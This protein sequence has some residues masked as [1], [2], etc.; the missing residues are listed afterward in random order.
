MKSIVS[1]CGFVHLNNLNNEFYTRV[2]TTPSILDQAITDITKSRFI[3][4]LFDFPSFDHRILLIDKSDKIH[5][6]TTNVKTTFTTIDY[7]QL[8]N[9]LTRSNRQYNSFKEMIDN[10]SGL[11]TDNTKMVKKKN[12]HE[13]WSTAEFHTL[14]KIRD[15]FY[16]LKRKYP[17]NSYYETRFKYFRNQAVY[18]KRMLKSQFYSKEMQS[19]ISNPKKLWIIL[20]GMLLNTESNNENKTI[21]AIL[22]R[23]SELV[24]DSMKIAN[25]LNNHFIN[26]SNHNHHNNNT[27]P[28]FA[29]FLHYNNLPTFDISLHLSRSF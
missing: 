16:V 17:Q 4:S 13:T 20:K 21:I 10:Y 1:S 19:S 26:I 12:Q 29:T 23:N 9:N 24:Y 25:L 2:S 8:I 7:E 3:T 5:N 15:M 14:I 27:G 11:I 18:L 6:S 22:N 28:H